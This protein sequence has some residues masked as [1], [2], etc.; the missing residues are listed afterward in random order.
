MWQERKIRTWIRCEAEY[1]GQKAYLKEVVIFAERQE[2]RRWSSDERRSN[3]KGTQHCVASWNQSWN[4]DSACSNCE[5]QRDILRP[6]KQFPSP[7]RLIRIRRSGFPRACSRHDGKLQSCWMIGTGDKA[8][9]HTTRRTKAL[10]PGT[11][12]AA[13]CW[14]ASRAY[15]KANASLP[16]AQFL[17]YAGRAAGSNP[18]LQAPRKKN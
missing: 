13:A 8:R 18:L 12:Q 10:L 17:R 2:S 5:R 14:L 16:F 4:L 3:Q 6:G 15:E 1:S 7:W 9:R 11:A